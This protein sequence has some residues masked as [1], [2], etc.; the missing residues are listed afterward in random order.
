VSG[1]LIGG[2]VKH[3]SFSHARD[4]PKRKRWTRDCDENQVTRKNSG[5][6]EWT[7]EDEIGYDIFPF[8]GKAYSV[9]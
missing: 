4:Q 6:Q 8:A 7:E 2:I 1:S 5:T 3:S 9:Q